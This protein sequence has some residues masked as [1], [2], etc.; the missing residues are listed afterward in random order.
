MS[1]T[2]T[3]TTPAG[4]TYAYT[5]ETGENGEAVYDLS[6]VFQEGAFP[7]GAVVVH[8]NWEL[9]PET[10]GLLNVQFG[11]GSGEDRHERTD[12]PMLGDGELPYVV[13]SHLINPADLT[14]DTDGENTPL[15]HFRKRVL[16]AAF[17]TSAPA[18]LASKETYEKVRDLVTA[19][20][21]VYQDDTDTPAR[22]AVY[23]KFL[24][25]K[26]AQAIQTEIDQLDTKIQALTIQ[27]ATLT[28]KLNTY[29]TA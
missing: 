22:E 3:F 4:N 7:I 20:I 17:P 19:L 13:G 24:N 9:F 1:G 16:G 15:L 2:Q 6:Q 18:E 21:K 26:R 23:A 11:K 12:A 10:A 27:R 8:P 25:A 5:V 29:K 14:A 28:E